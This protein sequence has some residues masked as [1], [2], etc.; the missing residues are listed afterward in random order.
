MKYLSLCCLIFFSFLQSMKDYYWKLPF[1]GEEGCVI[2]R[3]VRG[4]S[5]T[6]SCFLSVVF[7]ETSSQRKAVNGR[8]RIGP[9]EG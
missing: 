2:G 1:A 4:G 8:A 6:F 9:V 3:E 7:T 5:I